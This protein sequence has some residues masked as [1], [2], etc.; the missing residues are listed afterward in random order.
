MAL[1]NLEVDGIPGMTSTLVS[2]FKH[3]A[4]PQSFVVLC[5]LEVFSLDR[6]N[7][8]SSGTPEGLQA[9]T[10]PLRTG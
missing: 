10:K 5:F 7:S 1:E 9:C 6:F 4:L 2:V 3:F 8:F